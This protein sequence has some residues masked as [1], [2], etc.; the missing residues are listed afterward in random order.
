METK[1]EGNVMEATFES[2]RVYKISPVPVIC[3]TN[4]DLIGGEIQIPFNSD[5]LP[6]DVLA[7]VEEFYSEFCKYDPLVKLVESVKAMGKD[8]AG[9]IGKGGE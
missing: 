8:V 6:A 9:M 1:W 5:D 4:Q 2:G 3:E 7:E